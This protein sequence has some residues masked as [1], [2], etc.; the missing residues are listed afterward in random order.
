MA[1][2]ILMGGKKQS[3]RVLRPFELKQF[4][5]GIDKNKYRIMF[6]ACLYTGMRYVEMQRLQRHH[7][8]FDPDT[9]FIQLPPKSQKKKKQLLKQRWVRLN[10]R[11]ADKVS[12]FLELGKKLP[13]YSTWRDNLQ[14]WAKNANIDPI[15]INTR[16]TRKTYESYLVFCYPLY[17]HEIFQSQGHSEMTSLRHYLSMPFTDEDK[18]DMQEYVD[19]WIK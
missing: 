10:S 13:K 1:N 15:G 14:R 9:R 12:I 17:T 8:W 16:T 6:E 11:G 19:G 7:K 4:L 2:P 18:K 3:T 5:R